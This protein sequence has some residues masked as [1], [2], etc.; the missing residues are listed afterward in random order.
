[1]GWM[2][3]AEVWFCLLG[4]PK[5]MHWLQLASGW[6]WLQVWLVD[7]GDATSSYYRSVALVINY[8]LQLS[9]CLL[10]VVVAVGRFL[11]VVVV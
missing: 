11:L 10:R 8:N 6:P 7:R 3:I 4:L 2:Q 5:M 1:M 9:W